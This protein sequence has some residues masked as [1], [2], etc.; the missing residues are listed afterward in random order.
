MIEVL[1]FLV[2]IAVTCV[3]GYFLKSLT[4]SGALLAFI[5][6]IGVFIGFDVKGLLLLGVFFASSS[7]WS[8]YKSSQKAKVEEKLAKGARRDWRQVLANG[9]VALIVSIFFYYSHHSIW[10]IAFSVAIASSNSDTWAS[11][12]GSLSKQNP[13]YIRTLKRT[14]KGTSGAISPLGS[15]AALL[16]SLLI[17]SL[18]LWLFH[19]NLLSGFIIFTFGFIGNILD[20]LFGAYYQQ[21]FI[22]E[23]CGMETEKSIHCHKPSA[24]I[25][26][27]ASIDNDMV[28]FLSGFF[29]VILALGFLLAIKN[30]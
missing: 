10:M 19:L 20:T 25:K 3:T 27:L 26:G 1:F 11:E 13:I 9:G 16:G 18:S 15:I 21:A 5:V 23:V 30:R 14:E 8:K 7:L 22:C 6:G 17:A 24:R 4:F 29:A 12:I 28:N 2:I